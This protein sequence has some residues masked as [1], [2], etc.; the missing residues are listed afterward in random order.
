MITETQMHSLITRGSFTGSKVD[1]EKRQILGF[2]VTT[3]GPA[4]G[5]GETI[6]EE[7]L[8]QV[9]MM[10]N[11]VSAGGPVRA[12]MD[13]P[14]RGDMTIE[15]PLAKLLGRPFN[16]RI[17]GN[18]V[19]ADLQLLSASA[20]PDGDRLMALAEEAPS[21]FG[22]SLVFDYADPESHMAAVKKGKNPA[23]RFGSIFAVDFVDL[24]A[25]NPSG[26]FSM[27]PK[28]EAVMAKK[29]AAYVRN[30]GLFVNVGGEEFELDM[31]SEYGAKADEPDGDEGEESAKG[32]KGGKHGR[33]AAALDAQKI[34]DDAIA[35]ERAY[36]GDFQTAM[37]SAELKDKA[38]DDFRK[39]FYGRPI[40]DVKYL[41]A[42]SIGQRAK[43]V[44]EGEGEKTAPKP[45]EVAAKKEA[46]FVAQC[47]TD[48]NAELPDGNKRYGMF[49]VKQGKGDP[50]YKE[51]LARYIAAERKLQ[52]A[53][54]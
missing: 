52:P 40:A 13:H 10:G 21:M 17:E 15:N 32:G 14:P 37:H 31:P 7:S 9:V 23:V 54:A 34:R 3:I 28:K 43:P 46:D 25:T 5:H 22:A 29:L 26:L 33:K 12:R 27:S 41:A 11:A 44:G 24:P 2:V 30:S 36:A 16:F 38:A 39:E 6:D 4:L 49:G 35:S 45:E 18:C 48:F 50:R 47:E 20:A 51:M 8:Q 1:R 53:T 42:H 19:R